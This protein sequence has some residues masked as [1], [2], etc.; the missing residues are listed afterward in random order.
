M[1]ARF[2]ILDGD[3]GTADGLVRQAER[4]GYAAFATADP[5][6]LGR[7]VRV[8]RPRIVALSCDIAGTDPIDLVA[9]VAASDASVRLMLF[10]RIARLLEICRQAALI[11]GVSSAET[12]T[13]PIDFRASPLFETA[14]LPALAV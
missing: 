8:L 13:T 11:L 2:L 7:L 14:D 5:G 12:R 9:T 6:E 3:G 1:A 4:L 10:G